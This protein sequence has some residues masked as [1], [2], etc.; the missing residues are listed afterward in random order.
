MV[1]A[2]LRLGDGSIEHIQGTEDFINLLKTRLCF[3]AGQLLEEFVR[4]L[5]S[6]I[7]GLDIE[8]H[9]YESSNESYEAGMRDIQDNV[10]NLRQTLSS[11][12][13]SKA[14]RGRVMSLL[15]QI[16]T[17]LSNHV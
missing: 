6:K 16:E 12:Y 11:I 14:N 8:L 7:E 17:E 4:H 5:E 13:L 2:I 10:K 1:K 15:T 3:E 9:N